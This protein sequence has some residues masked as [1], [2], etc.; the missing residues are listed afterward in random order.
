[1]TG[2]IQAVQYAFR[3]MRNPP[4]IDEGRPPM[5]VVRCE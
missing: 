1:M 2:L 3:Q 4:G 5:L